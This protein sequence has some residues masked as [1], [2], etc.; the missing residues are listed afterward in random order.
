MFGL[1][2]IPFIEVFG[3]F[4]VGLVVAMVVVLTVVAA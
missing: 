2:M 4:L 1:Q 3:G